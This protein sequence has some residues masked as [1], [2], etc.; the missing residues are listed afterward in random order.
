M[1]WNP[2]GPCI[3]FSAWEKDP[4]SFYISWWD[5]WASRLQWAILLWLWKHK[6][7]ILQLVFRIQYEDTITPEACYWVWSLAPLN[8][9]RPCKWWKCFVCICTAGP[10]V[11]WART[12]QSLLCMEWGAVRCCP[13]TAAWWILPTSMWLPAAAC[14]GEGAGAFSEGGGRQEHMCTGVASVCPRS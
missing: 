10:Q 14:V 5:P 13:S 9:Q 12:F 8:P 2:S 6:A 3:A 7:G 11:P 1:I 4:H